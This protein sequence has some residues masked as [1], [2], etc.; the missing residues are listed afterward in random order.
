M[1]IFVSCALRNVQ[2]HL[3]SLPTTSSIRHDNQKCLH[4]LPDVPW[5]AKLS[6]VRTTALES[7]D[8]LSW[9]RQLKLRTATS[10]HQP[11]MPNEQGRRRTDKRQPAAHMA[12]PRGRTLSPASSS[13]S[14]PPPPSLPPRPASAPGAERTPPGDYTGLMDISTLH[15][16]GLLSNVLME[17]KDSVTLGICDVC[18]S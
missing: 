9:E 1:L 3:W 14:P 12:R 6:P 10:Q 8:G 11:R 2:Q 4:T 7:K 16:Q 15:D 17:A 5:G 13:P 18:H